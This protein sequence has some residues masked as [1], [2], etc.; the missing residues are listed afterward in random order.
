MSRVLASAAIFA[1][2]VS[3]LMTQA[4]A[5]Q[6]P[7]KRVLTLEAAKRM[8]AAAEAEAK[9]NNWLVSIAVV[10]DGGHLILFQRMDGAKLVTFDIA[11]RKASTAV[12]FQGET[13][14]LEEE[15][16][17][18]GRTALLPIAGFMPLEG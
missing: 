9:K 14:G 16:S 7:T 6:L 18:Q 17:K 4:S 11:T 1:L 8:A 12:L 13:K 2:V 15:V 5:H 3:T 10:D